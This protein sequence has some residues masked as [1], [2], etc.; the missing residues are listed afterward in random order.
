MLPSHEHKQNISESGHMTKMLGFI[1]QAMRSMRGIVS[2]YD[3]NI[4]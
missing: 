4:S 3:Y 2:T 1:T